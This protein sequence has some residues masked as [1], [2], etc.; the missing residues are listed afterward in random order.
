MIA[1]AGPTGSGK[2]ALALRLAEEFSGEVVNCDSMQLYRGF[3]IATAKVPPG[4]RRG[5]AH[6]MIDVVDASGVYSAGDYAREARRVLAEISARG[7][8]P[9]V[10]GGTGFYLRALLH[11]LPRLPGRDPAVRERLEGRET[12]R[13]HRL[14]TRLDPTAA[15]RIHPHD[16][17]KVIRAL[18]IRVLTGHSAPPSDSADPLMGYCPLVLG[19]DPDRAALYRNLDARAAEMFRSG[20]IEEVEGLL[21]QGATGVEKPFESLGY[22][23]ALAHLRGAISLK[24]AIALTQIATRQ[25]AKRQWT[26]FRKD[27]SVIWLRGFG[28]EPAVIE[29][30][31]ERVRNFRDAILAVKP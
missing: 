27:A 8:L 26:W 24:D 16:R 14:L 30:S 15:G 22:K 25:Y 17:Q 21:K 10:V 4:E 20:L 7:N 11:G 9:I 1:V 31:F 28:G 19:L 23:E 3:D 18:E 29:E 12:P 6:H 13:L 2:S 5:V